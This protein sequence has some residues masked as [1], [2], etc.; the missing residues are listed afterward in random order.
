MSSLK[1]FREVIRDIKE[2]EIWI[3]LSENRRVEQI[4]LR[5]NI[6][7]LEGKAKFETN[8]VGV[9][10]NDKFKLK[11]KEYSFNEAFKYY[12]EGEEIESIFSNCKYKNIDGIHY[13][14]DK[15]SGMFAQEWAACDGFEISEI[16]EKWYINN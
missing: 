3:N 15:I 9:F 16:R 6:L 4:Q 14:K 7:A 12:E 13:F 8:G 2:G 1:T 5:K 11:R 10:L